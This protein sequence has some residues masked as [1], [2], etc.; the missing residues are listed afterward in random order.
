MGSYKVGLL[1]EARVTV[2]LDEVP[3][4]L[5]PVQIRVLVVLLQVPAQYSTYIYIH[6]RCTYST[7]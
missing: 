3:Q 1:E 6:V 2:R 7:F 5:V 4:R